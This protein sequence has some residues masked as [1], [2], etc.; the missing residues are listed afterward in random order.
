MR[1]SIAVV[2]LALATAAPAVPA[3]QLVRVAAAT[4]P[5]VPVTGEGCGAFW[6]DLVGD[7]RLDLFVAN[8]NG[9]PQK[10]ALYR[11]TRNGG[12]VRVTT[13]AVA[14]DSVSSSGVTA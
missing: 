8:G 14:T 10:N 6:L 1:P 5:I 2:A 11:N 4:N 7:G 13:G 3:Q 12:F 9:T